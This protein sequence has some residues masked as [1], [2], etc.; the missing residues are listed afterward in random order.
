[1]KFNQVIYV[2]IDNKYYY[3]NKYP[4]E[5]RVFQL[6]FR[7]VAFNIFENETSYKQDQILIIQPDCASL[8]IKYILFLSMV[9]RK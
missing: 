3:F 8:S 9:I 7:H 1:V 2:E 6:M 5:E 4:D